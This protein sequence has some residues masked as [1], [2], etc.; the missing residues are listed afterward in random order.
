MVAGIIALAA[1]LLFAASLFAIVSI[2]AKVNRLGSSIDDR[3]SDI[4][5]ARSQKEKT[6]N[7]RT[8]AAEDA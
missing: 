5:I 1:V 2:S 6:E 7:G 8:A 4:K 3:P